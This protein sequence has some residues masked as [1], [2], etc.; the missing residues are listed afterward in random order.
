M[1]KYERS[2]SGPSKSVILPP[3]SLP[4]TSSLLLGHRLIW[5]RRQQ[6]R[7]YYAD[8]YPHQL[9]WLVSSFI[10]FVAVCQF[11]SFVVGKYQARSK[12]TPV[13]TESNKIQL[14]RLPLA[15]VNYWR[16]LS[17]RV[18]IGIGSYT[19]NLAEVFLTCAYIVALFTWEFINSKNPSFPFL[20]YGPVTYPNILFQ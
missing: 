9:W 1:F 18:N 15:L 14:S 10:A 12:S 4:W 5:R 8:E 7:A 13:A 11:T 2:S 19:L 20:S 17:Y 6:W 3:F 16:V